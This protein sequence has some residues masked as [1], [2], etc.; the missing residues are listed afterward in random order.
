[1]AKFIKVVDTNY[2]SEFYYNVNS[3]VYYSASQ[4]GEERAYLL[5][6][7]GNYVYV[8]D[9]VEEITAQIARD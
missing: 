5:L 7:N 4:T 6:T 9:T 8:N 2:Q 3:I 1:M